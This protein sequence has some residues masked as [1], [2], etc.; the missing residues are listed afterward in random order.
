ML[1]LELVVVLVLELALVLVLVLAVVLVLVLLLL[2]LPALGPS[3]SSLFE[4]SWEPLRACRAKGLALPWL[5]HLDSWKFL[6]SCPERGLRLGKVVDKFPQGG[7]MAHWPS[8]PQLQPLPP[9]RA[10]LLPCPSAHLDHTD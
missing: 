4:L 1:V 8:C 10:W 6:T 7:H 9:T 3:S 5:G 2:L